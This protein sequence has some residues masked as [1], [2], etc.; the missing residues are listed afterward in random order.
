MDI[1]PIIYFRM[2]KIP[3]WKIENKKK[4]TFLEVMESEEDIERDPNR[5]IKKTKLNK[6]NEERKEA[7]TKRKQQ[8]AEKPVSDFI[9]HKNIGNAQKVTKGI[10]KDPI[11]GP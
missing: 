7:E 2:Y 1:E 8:E 5:Q 11:A 3:T 9:K 6:S 10:L 4:I